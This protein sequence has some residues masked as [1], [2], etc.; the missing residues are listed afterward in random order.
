MSSK[1]GQGLVYRFCLECSQVF[2]GFYAD[3][4]CP[5]CRNKFPKKD[6]ILAE[7]YHS[8]M[9]SGMDFRPRSQS[10]SQEGF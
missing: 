1:E 2:M 7:R 5:R 6:A 3:R 4:L 9:S 10:R 8:S